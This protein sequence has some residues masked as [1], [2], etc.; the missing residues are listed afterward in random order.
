M[1]TDRRTS[2]LSPVGMVLGGRLLP[3]PWKPSSC[4]GSCSSP[5]LDLLFG[6]NLAAPLGLPLL[7]SWGSTYKS[8]LPLSGS[9]SWGTAGTSL[10]CV[11][12]HAT[13]SSLPTR[14]LPCPSGWLCRQK[15][16]P[17]FPFCD[18]LRYQKLH[19]LGNFQESSC[20]S[21]LGRGRRRALRVKGTIL[22][23]SPAGYK[24][25]SLPSQGTYF[26][27]FHGCCVFV[28]ERGEVAKITDTAR[29]TLKSGY[30]AAYHHPHFADQKTEVWNITLHA[31]GHPI[32]RR[33]SWDEKQNSSTK[34]ETAPDQ[35]TECIQD[36][37]AFVG[38]ASFPLF[39]GAAHKDTEL[40]ALKP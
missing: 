19:S 32:G 21:A 24:P 38:E 5:H 2:F 4:P 6:K 29:G 27:H 37:F 15:S 22:V 31:R 39:R 12:S 30:V 23:P 16:I 17:L 3:Q 13:L 7:A 26:P 20:P 1:G 33:W 28:G 35:S 8:L 40:G 9:H 34:A 11:C 14:P 18:L 10:L 25:V 36:Q